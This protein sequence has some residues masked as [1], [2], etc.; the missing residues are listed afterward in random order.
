MPELTGLGTIQLAADFPGFQIQTV[1]Q[2][3]SVHPEP[4]NSTSM[5][6]FERAVS[7]SRLWSAP[8]QC[9]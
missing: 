9:S 6:L 1:S 4:D 8:A 5:E 7:M 3:D 2:F